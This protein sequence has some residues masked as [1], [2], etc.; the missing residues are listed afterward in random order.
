MFV[1]CFL[2]AFVTESE[3]DAITALCGGPRDKDVDAAFIDEPARIVFVIQGKYRKEVGATTEH[4]GD[5]AGFAQLAVD[6]SGDSKVFSSLAKDM[7][8]EV[9]HKLTEKLERQRE[10]RILEGKRDEAWRAFDQASREIDQQKDTLLD[11]ISQRLEQKL[12]QEQLFSVQ[13]RLT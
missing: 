11:E 5:V 1:L 8:P 2:R 4:R 6:L 13:W 3:P 12:E 9:L 7:S 10:A